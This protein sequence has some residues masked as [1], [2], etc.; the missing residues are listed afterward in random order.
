[1]YRRQFCF[2]LHDKDL[3]SLMEVSREQ[4]KKPSVIIREALKPV[5]QASQQKAPTA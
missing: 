4:G 2:R 3:A 5:L 1:M